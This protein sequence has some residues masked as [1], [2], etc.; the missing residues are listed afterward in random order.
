MQVVRKLQGLGC[1]SISCCSF[2]TAETVMSMPDVDGRACRPLL[3]MPSTRATR[4]RAPL[5]SV[6][7]SE[8]SAAAF[9][10]ANAVC[11]S[12]SFFCPALTSS[13]KAA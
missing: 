10:A 5:A 4:C 12:A 7:A 9:A 1:C 8:A 2:S 6:A 3:S 11:A 13:A